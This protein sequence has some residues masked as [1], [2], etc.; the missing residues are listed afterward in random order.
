MYVG[1]SHLCACFF[2]ECSSCIQRCVSFGARF[3]FGE[4]AFAV[5]LCSPPLPFH[6]RSL[7]FDSSQVPFSF[8]RV[9]FLHSVYPL[10][11][12]SF[13]FLFSSLR[14]A[15]RAPYFR[16]TRWRAS[17]SLDRF[18]VRAFARYKKRCDAVLRSAARWETTRCSAVHA[19]RQRLSASRVGAVCR[20]EVSA[21][22]EKRCSLNTRAWNETAIATI[23]TESNNDSENS[24]R[25]Q[26]RQ[27]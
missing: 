26:Q 5:S 22:A 8:L 19:R 6:H 13:P 20:G 7:R 23:V 9:C 1:L 12:L 2:D 27:R 10:S 14:P 18:R 16:T 15:I 24:N 25:K 17:G 3:D 4:F 21:P 11:F